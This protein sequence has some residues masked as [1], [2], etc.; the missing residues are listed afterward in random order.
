M[1]DVR[2]GN[3]HTLLQPRHYEMG[4]CFNCDNSI[5]N[6]E[7]IYHKKNYGF[8][9]GYNLGLNRCVSKEDEYIILLNP[10]AMIGDTFIE[11]LVDSINNLGV[12]YIYGVKH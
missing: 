8:G 5:K 4:K 9:K 12:N 7:I 11:D 3:C 6:H 10:D 1:P 2:C